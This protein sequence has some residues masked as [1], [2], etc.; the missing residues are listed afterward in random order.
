MI[1]QTQVWVPLYW[2]T[3]YTVSS[4]KSIAKQLAHN[5]FLIS[6]YNKSTLPVPLYI[7]SHI[8]IPS[9]QSN[10]ST[11]CNIIP[12][13]LYT[14]LTHNSHTS[15]LTTNCKGDSYVS[16]IYVNITCIQLYNKSSHNT[17]TMFKLVPS[18][19]TGAYLFG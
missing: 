5:S 2:F 4:P 19:H 7:S 3:C 15:W 10:L 6:F 12:H 8:P 1:A 13:W 9:R 18:S 14:H 16:Q 17:K 11:K